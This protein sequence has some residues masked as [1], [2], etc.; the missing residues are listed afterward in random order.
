MPRLA[1]RHV[2]VA[3]FLVAGRNGHALRGAVVGRLN[4][5]HV[6]ASR[7]AGRARH[8]E[9]APKATAPPGSAD[10]GSAVVLCS[11]Q[12]KPASLPLF[13]VGVGDH[14]VGRR[15]ISS[16]SQ[17]LKRGSIRCSGR[18][19]T[20][21]HTGPSV[22]SSLAIVNFLSSC[23]AAADQHVGE[24]RDQHAGETSRTARKP[25]ESTA[26]WPPQSS[27]YLRSS[28]RAGRPPPLRW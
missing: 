7:P 19:E 27:T 8:V 9:P 21:R 11:P 4:A 6:V 18:S 16:S 5:R 24:L 26:A 10:A 1:A 15:Q 12:V 13:F 3:I 28:P 25:T 22:R 20:S 2:Q 17:F 23:L 14:V